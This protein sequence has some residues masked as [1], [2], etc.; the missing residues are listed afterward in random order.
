MR[1]QGLGREPLRLCQD[2]VVEVGEH[3]R[4]E[5]DV[6]LNEHNHLHAGFLDV[7]FDVHLVLN[8]LDDAHDEVGVS[9]PAEHIV[10]HRHVL[11]L[12]TFGDT[13]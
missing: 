4:V 11:I 5:P 9:Q 6:I 13:M 8:E 10:E 7:V 2:I 12:N 1:V 3:T